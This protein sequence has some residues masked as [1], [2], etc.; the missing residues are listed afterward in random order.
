MTF[1]QYN[2]PPFNKRL[3]YAG[4]RVGV[5]EHCRGLDPAVG[6]MVQSHL[7]M[8]PRHLVT[9]DNLVPLALLHLAAALGGQDELPAFYPTN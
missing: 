3:A 6:V 5:A 7:A 1:Q 2:L 8:C 4:N 9:L